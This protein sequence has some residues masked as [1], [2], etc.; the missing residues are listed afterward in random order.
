MEFIPLEQ[1]VKGTIYK[2]HSR[3]LRIG[4]FNGDTGFIGIRE[5][6]G[7]EY[8]FTEYHYDCGAGGYGTVRPIEIIAELPK[9]IPLKEY[10]SDNI[11]GNCGRNVIFI[12]D[13]PA[14]S[15]PGTWHH[16]PFSVWDREEEEEEPKLFDF[17]DCKP[18]PTMLQNPYLFDYL[19]NLEKENET[20][21]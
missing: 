7:H 18:R 20:R 9:W 15:T 21:V 6:F 19:I 5:K 4:V 17:G 12:P 2:I 3:N 13:D 8:L 1:C 16:I 10:L 14:T 11:C